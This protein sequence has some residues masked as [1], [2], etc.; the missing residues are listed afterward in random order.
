M[1]VFDFSKTERG[2]LFFP[3]K[4]LK[5]LIPGDQIFW[6]ES[7]LLFKTVHIEANYFGVSSLVALVSSLPRGKRADV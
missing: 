7:F 4:I 5:L 2:I 1:A 6:V 3:S